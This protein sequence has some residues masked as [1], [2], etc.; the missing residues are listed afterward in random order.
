MI[1]GDHMLA[2]ILQPFYR[3]SESHC[4]DQDKDVFR[5]NLAT[6]SKSAA[7]V[8]FIEMDSGGAPP[9]H[10]R[11]GFAVTMRYLGGAM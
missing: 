11:Q 1:G 4:C 10:P 5:I 2:P 9:K 8:A 7:N 6:D 3:P